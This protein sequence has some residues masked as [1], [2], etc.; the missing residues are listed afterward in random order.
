SQKALDNLDRMTQGEK[1]SFASFLTRFEKE[2]ADSGAFAWSDP[3]KINFLTRSLNSGM[4]KILLTQRGM[5]HGYSDF[6]RDLHELGNN[7]DRQRYQTKKGHYTPR[8]RN[9]SPDQG[10]ARTHSF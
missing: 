3:A 5:P 8:A 1:E 7:L 10:A 4:S 9:H 2:L 6:L